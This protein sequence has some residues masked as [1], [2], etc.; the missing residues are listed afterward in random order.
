MD[1][2]VIE[3]AFAK[4]LSCTLGTFGQRQW[5]PQLQVK[6]LIAVACVLPF[7]HAAVIATL[8]LAQEF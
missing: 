1:C 3:H 6:A 7:L 5:Q 2:Q 4:K 8:I